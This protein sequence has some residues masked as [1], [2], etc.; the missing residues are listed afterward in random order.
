MLF[1]NMLSS[2]FLT[3]KNEFAKMMMGYANIL[4]IVVL[5]LIMIKKNLYCVYL[6]I[7]IYI[8]INRRAIFL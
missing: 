4:N 1:P 7:Y 3:T 5:R 8:Y 2:P 6:N